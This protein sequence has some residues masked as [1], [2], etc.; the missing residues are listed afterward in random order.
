MISYVMMYNPLSNTNSNYRCTTLDSA[1]IK[2]HMNGGYV[3]FDTV[4]IKIDIVID[5]INVGDGNTSY[6]GFI[7]EEINLFIYGLFAN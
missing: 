3:I 4:C 7:G 1:S 6:D 5:L 2:F